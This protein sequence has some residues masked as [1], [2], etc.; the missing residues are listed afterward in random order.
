M[1]MEVSETDLTV[2][3]LPPL[4]ALLQ[5]APKAAKITKLFHIFIISTLYKFALE[6]Y[7]D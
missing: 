6:T 7:K 3:P 1:R 2:G 4:P 5:R